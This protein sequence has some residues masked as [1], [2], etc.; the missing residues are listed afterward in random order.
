MAEQDTPGPIEPKRHQLFDLMVPLAG[1]ILVLFATAMFGLFSRTPNNVV[2][3]IALFGVGCAALW[4]GLVHADAS[5]TEK[6][7][8]RLREKA[9]KLQDLVEKNRR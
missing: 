4:F 7:I 6:R 1:V 8:E 5:A 9:D 3:A 2:I